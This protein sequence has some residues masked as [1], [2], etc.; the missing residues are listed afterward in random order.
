MNESRNVPDPY[1]VAYSERVRNELKSLI[2]RAKGRGLGQQVLAA[3]KELDYRLH[4]YPQFGQPLFDLKLEGA[5]VWI[6]T[7][8]PLTIKYVL[9]EKQRAVMVIQPLA[10]LP[11]SGLEP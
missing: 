8:P 4:I 2:A 1:R 9:D 3:L 11:G 6:A 5:Q 10:P 7:V